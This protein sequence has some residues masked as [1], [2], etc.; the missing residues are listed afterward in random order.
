MTPSHFSGCEIRRVLETKYPLLCGDGVPA[1][2]AEVCCCGALGG[3]QLDILDGLCEY[4]AGVSGERIFIPYA[5][6]GSGE[7][8]AAPRIILAR[9]EE[10]GGKL[11]VGVR[12]LPAEPPPERDLKFGRGVWEKTIEDYRRKVYGALDFAAFLSI[13]KNGRGRG[14]F[15][16][17]GGVS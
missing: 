12:F 3:G 11:A 5:G 14:A 17:A 9:C 10:T 8:V 7:E 13:E 2:G 15:G 6:R 1:N 4:L 16:G